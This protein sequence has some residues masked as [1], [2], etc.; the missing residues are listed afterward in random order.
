ML[1]TRLRLLFVFISL[2]AGSL[3]PSAAF[4]ATQQ[5]VTPIRVGICESD[6]NATTSQLIE[7]S[8]DRL[9]KIFDGSWTIRHID[10]SKLEATIEKHETDVLFLS[11]AQFTVTERFYGSMRWPALNSPVRKI[12]KKLSESVSSA[13]ILL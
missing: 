2:L 10:Q 5:V 12:H 6:V 8:I 7:Q 3:S 1:S 11:S 13:R 9:Q 4:A